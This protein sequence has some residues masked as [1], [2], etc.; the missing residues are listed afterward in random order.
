MILREELYELVW[1]QP[2][3][4][5]AEQFDVSGSYMARICTLLNVP[6]PER[7]Y[8]AKLAV[9]KAP[10][11]EPLPDAR[12]G[13]QLSW[14]QDGK[15]VAPP[16]PQSP[17]K[18]RKASQIR[19]PRNSFH[20]LV[21]GA[22]AHF[23]KGYPNRDDGYL[24]PYKKLLVDIVTSKECLDKALTFA[25]DLFNALESVGHRVVLA[26]SN[27]HLGRDRIDEREVPDKKKRENDYY[28]YN[29]LWSP[30]RPTVVYVGTVAI[31]LTIVEMSEEVLLRYVNGEYVRE[32]DYKPPKTSRY[33]ADHTWTTTK[34]LPSG[35]LRLVA[36]CPYRRVSWSTHWQETDK[37]PVGKF[38]P[39]IVRTIEESA[40]ELVGKL[41]EAERQA[42]IAHRKWLIEDEK[43]RRAEDR[44]KIEQS[45]QESRQHLGKIIEQWSDVISVERFLTGVEERV[46]TLP[47]DERGEVLQRL[48]L[49]RDFLGTQDP[50]DFFLSWRIPSERYQPL[51]EIADEDG[52]SETGGG[53]H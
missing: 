7:G 16:K 17:P 52:H 51:Y 12:P 23:E 13:D 3:T 22:K 53:E 31:G 49:A 29:R 6:R 42:E 10:L 37:A 9:G 34:S 14:S 20:R 25:N 18:R 2:M 41:E 4:K 30:H 40:H 39:A 8:W 47:D 43:R 46:S 15:R 36:Y 21:S 1:S 33:Y 48:K 38:L 26:P 27:E 19:I 44:R 24:K 5:I 50:L 32:A 11:R 28:Y 35:R 45:V